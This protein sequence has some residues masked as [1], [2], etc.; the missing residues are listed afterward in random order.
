MPTPISRKP[1]KASREMRRQVE[2]LRASGFNEDAI[3]V[4][5]EISPTT[6]RKF[7]RRELDDGAVRANARVALAVH[8]AA[9]EGSPAAARLWRDGYGAVERRG[10]AR[11]PPP[12]GKKA[13]QE[14]E[15]ETAAEGT[16]WAALVNETDS[17]RPN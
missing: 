16:S 13:R 12:L 17:D 2:V 7:F 5:L 4:A 15:S 3:A 9:V 14:R 10:R 1:F 8:R 11:K 6:L